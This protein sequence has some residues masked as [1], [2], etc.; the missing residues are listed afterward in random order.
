MR[1]KGIRADVIDNIERMYRETKL[2]VKIGNIYTVI[3]DREG[4]RTGFPT[5]PAAVREKAERRENGNGKA[6][7]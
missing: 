1:G 7:K 2:K 5:E 4:G 3:L 6:R